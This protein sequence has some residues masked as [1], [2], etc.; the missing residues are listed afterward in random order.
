MPIEINMR[1][2][3]AETW[4][5]IKT[6]YDVDLLEEYLNISLGF[7]LD[8]NVLEHKSRN[9]RFKCISKDIHPARNVLLNSIKVNLSSL[10]HSDS[11]AEV[12]IFRSPGD[13]LTR[14]DYVGWF[15]IKAELSET[16]EKLVSS[17]S[18]SIKL[19]AI[20]FIDL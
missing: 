15:T 2:G 17:V 9:P 13:I 1:M 4:S 16:N 5:M 18:E 3:G 7:R 19:V 20:E 12:C 10:D 14:E 6:A 8:Q 11:V